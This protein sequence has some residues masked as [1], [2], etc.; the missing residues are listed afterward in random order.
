MVWYVLF[1]EAKWFAEQ[2]CQ[3]LQIDSL[4]ISFKHSVISLMKSKCPHFC[5]IVVATTLSKSSCLNNKCLPQI[6][7]KFYLFSDCFVETSSHL[8]SKYFLQ[9]KLDKI[10]FPY[11]YCGGSC[12]SILRKRNYRKLVAKEKHNGRKNL[13]TSFLIFR[14]WE[15]ATI[16]K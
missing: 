15:M 7:F 13:D 9:K 2:S 12:K 8:I 1:K 14:T 4:K 16:Y 11:N 5:Q 6:L 3:H 10:L